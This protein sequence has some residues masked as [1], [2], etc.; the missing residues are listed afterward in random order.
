MSMAE[1]SS[2]WLGPD[3]RG[4]KLTRKWSANVGVTATADGHGGSRRVSYLRCCT[5]RRSYRLLE[6]STDAGCAALA[7]WRSL[8]QHKIIYDNGSTTGP[9]KRR[10]MSETGGSGPPRQQGVGC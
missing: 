9:G 5:R 6:D 4:A 3:R 7:V 2:R 10:Q 1:T 8:Q